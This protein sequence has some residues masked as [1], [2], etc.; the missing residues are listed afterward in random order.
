MY[1]ASGSEISA[2]NPL[3]P[4]AGS[5]FSNGIYTK[6]V[7]GGNANI[8]AAVT[9]P[10]VFY[11]IDGSPWNA[12]GDTSAN[13]LW[14]AT[15]SKSPFD[16]CPAGWR[17]PAFENGKSPWNG[18]T[19]DSQG[20]FNKGYNWDALGYY[21]AA[22]SRNYTNGT[23]NLVGSN[24]YYWASSNSDTYGCYLGFLSGAVDTRYSY[25]RSYGFSVRCVSSQN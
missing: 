3:T 22:G 25:N 17:V 12:E 13:E 6:T 8:A 1:D 4:P 16:P 23:I 7:T 2:T 21:P 20:T 11:G 9:Q 14:G 15:G 5:T 24:G 19:K 18:M 10:Q